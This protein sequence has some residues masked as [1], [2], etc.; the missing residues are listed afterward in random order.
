MS[1]EG[2]DNSH[3]Q[4]AEE[5]GRKNKILISSVAGWCQ[6]IK[7]VG[8][9][10]SML[11]KMLDIPMS[12]HISCPQMG[13]DGYEGPNLEWNARDFIIEN[14]INC[15][16]HTPITANNFGIEVVSEHFKLKRKEEE[17]EKARLDSLAK[18]RDEAEKLIIREKSKAE[19]KKLSIIKLIE[20]LESPD[21]AKDISEKILQAARLSPEFFS[22]AAI[23]Y[24]SLFL[25]NEEYGN[26]LMQAISALQIAKHHISEFASKN[27]IS[28]IINRKSFDLAVS[29]WATSVADEKLPLFSDLFYNIVKNCRYE[30]FYHF[31]EEKAGSYP[32]SINLLRRLHASHPDCYKDIFHKMLSDEDTIIRIN[33]NGLLQDMIEDGIENTINFLPFL[34]RSFDFIDKERGGESG[35]NQTLKTIL[36]LYVKNPDEVMKVCLSDGSKLSEWGTAELVEVYERIVMEGHLYKVDE[37]F[38]AEA[39][40]RLNQFLLGDSKKTK[41]VE[42]ALDA[43]GHIASQRP[44]ALT[45][46]FDPYIGFLIKSNEELQKFEWYRRDALSALKPMATFNPLIGKNF[47]EI[48]NMSMDLHKIFQNAGQIVIKLIEEDSEEFMTGLLQVVEKISSKIDGKFK[49]KLIGL[50]Q[51][52]TKD[53][54]SIG[55][56]LPVIYSW[57][58]DAESE[59][60]RFAGMKFVV[61]LIERYPQLVT[62]TLIGLVKVFFDDKVV[63]VRG[64][65]IDAYAEIV[66][67]FPDQVEKKYFDKIYQLISDKFVFVHKAAISF[68]YSAYPFLSEN[69]K[70]LWTVELYRYAD[71]YCKKDDYSYGFEVVK[72]TLYF[73]AGNS[74]VHRNIVESLIVKLCTCGDYY[75]EKDTLLYLTHLTKSNKNYT[76]IWMREAIGF[77]SRTLPKGR[78]QSNDDRN[79]IMQFFFKLDEQDII[80]HK[81]LIVAHVKNYIDNIDLPIIPDVIHFHGVFAYFNLWK[82][83]KLLSEYFSAKVPQLSKYDSI[84]RFNQRSLRIA[85]TEIHVSLGTINLVYINNLINARP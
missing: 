62:E 14:C 11:G 49:A 22:E 43:L 31:G 7:V 34:V 46:H 20:K 16:K 2:I 57:L 21:G 67:Q 26:K 75:Q 55:N 61:H 71:H 45:P 76:D 5:M 39:V 44:E 36:K 35:D 64:L 50:V 6:H 19:V 33:I 30:N 41:L 9:R 77:L 3:F 68:S 38:S 72:K 56:I 29:I 81:D 24:I 42:S 82:S 83:V 80:E 53:I 1:K 74:K 37:D 51:K 60:V 12:T 48:E 17:E 25:Q 84:H 63:G 28:A 59:D 18:L 32:N 69:E 23:N 58:H 27:V 13:N 73:A 70:K 78:Y 47:M 79:E 54:I 85:E 4:Q 40:I 15:G 10:A 52:S 65:A 66:K 8:Y